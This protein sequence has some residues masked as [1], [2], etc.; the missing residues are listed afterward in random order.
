MIYFCEKVQYEN[1]V[2]RALIN[3]HLLLFRKLILKVIEILKFDSSVLLDK[4]LVSISLLQLL[5]KPPNEFY[6]SVMKDVS[7]LKLISTLCFAGWKPVKQL[8]S[9][10]REVRSNNFIGHLHFLN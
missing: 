9:E 4:D 3:V 2:A 8:Q 6:T 7:K 5:A 1:T 10:L